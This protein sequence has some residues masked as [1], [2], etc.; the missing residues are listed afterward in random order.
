MFVFCDLCAKRTEKLPIFFQITSLSIL[1]GFYGNV[2][3]Q[4]DSFSNSHFLSTIF[5]I[6]RAYQGLLLGKPSHNPIRGIAD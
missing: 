5:F 3:Q 1:M 2:M 4:T 6:S